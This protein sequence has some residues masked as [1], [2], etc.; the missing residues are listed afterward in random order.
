MKADLKSTAAQVD[1]KMWV[2]EDTLAG[3]QFK[4]SNKLAPRRV[5]IKLLSLHVAKGPQGTR[6]Q[7]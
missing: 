6:K 5:S 7:R 4:G 2:K 1:V 3:N